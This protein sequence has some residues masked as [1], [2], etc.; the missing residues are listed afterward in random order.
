MSADPLDPPTLIADPPHAGGDEATER[1]PAL[2]IVW[3]P[4][5][6][7]I[8]ETAA[9]AEKRAEVSRLQPLFRSS[10]T[11][12]AKAAG[13]PTG[14]SAPGC[15]CSVS[16]RGWTGSICL[17]SLSDTHVTVDGAELKGTIA[18]SRSDLG[19]GALV[20]LA[21]RSVLCVHVMRSHSSSPPRDHGRRLEQRSGRDS[22]RN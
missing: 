5:T 14:I 19:R 10:R 21:H 7:R 22:A 11:A 2:I 17:S 15:P 6:T 16:R 8:G 4:D 12:G 13:W 1:V 3:H 20:V 18:L 9:L